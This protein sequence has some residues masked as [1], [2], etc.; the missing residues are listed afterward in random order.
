MT[1]ES[2][3]KKIVEAINFDDDLQKKRTQFIT[4]V[5][6]VDINGKLTT[7]ENIAGKIIQFLEKNV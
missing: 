4:K 1:Q 7:G 5:K 6:E 2:K 3:N